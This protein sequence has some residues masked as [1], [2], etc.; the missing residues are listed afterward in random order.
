MSHEL[1]TPL[2]SLL[3]L[4]KSLMDNKEG[5]LSADQVESARIIQSGGSDLLNL[6]NEILDLS[7]IEAGRMTIQPGTI[8]IS[9][10]ADDVCASF[11]HMTDKKGLKLEVVVR[12]GVPTE[13][14]S[15]RKRLDQIIRNLMSNAI[16]FTDS[17]GLTVTFA[18]T[19]PEVNLSRIGLSANESLS[20]EVRDTGIGIAPENQKIIFEAFQ[21]VDGGT[22][23]RYGG[24][25]LGL[26]ISRE[27][28]RL[29]GGEIKIES[30]LGKGSAFTLYLPVTVSPDRKIA[31]GNTNVGMAAK[32]DGVSVR[33]TVRTNVTA[34]QIDDDRNSLNK[35]DKVI[36]VIEDDPNF[37][38]L[39]YKKCHEKDFKCLTA[40][41]GEAGLEL[42]VKFLPSAVILDIS[43]PGINGWTVLDALKENI[44]TR[45]IPVHIVSAEDSSPE[46]VGKGAVGHATKPLSHDD[47][48]EA[49]RKFEMVSDG[50]LKRVLVVDD[51]VDTRRKTVKMISE[52]GIKVDEAENGKQAMEALRSVHYDCVVLDLRLPDMDGLNLL[53]RLES[54]CV[55]LPP[56][57]VYTCRELTR[58][59][60]MKIRGHAESIVIKDVRSQERLLDEVSLF[61]HQVVS[62]MPEKKRKIIRDLH[63]TD[64]ILRN[65]K[66]LV[67]DDDMRT[68]FAMSRILSEC[69]MN[70]LK[71]ENGDMALHLLE[72][73][74]DI[75][76]VLMDIMMPVM[77]GYEAMKRIR[78]QDRFRGL[79]IIVLTAK[80]MPEDREKCLAAGAND[81]L[82]K[83]VD[84]KR[85]VSMMRVWLCR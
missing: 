70:P 60:E 42:A 68:A 51:D 53:E 52:D 29:L 15:D 7:K 39:L 69:G 57:I 43:L 82:A 83:P 27:M 72:E 54:E 12:E 65:K 11:V 18:R 32:N 45:H 14:T 30:E 21:Q 44:V 24:T 20:I 77:D 9:D 3:I 13:I 76:L 47:L 79:P 74:P 78:K 50:K 84:Q 38:R 40:P 46:S 61:L 4:S 34:T 25:G 6:I 19:A 56:V 8:R 63:N 41:T 48:E 16:K 81:Y 67:V 2:N 73:N 31:T 17:G 85:L 66:V 75:D 26:S 62:K 22:A 5:N 55:K 71:A 35:E 49:F 33:N 36:L 59:E 64:E 23:R 10:L 1:R 58:E 28:S 80:A 37:A